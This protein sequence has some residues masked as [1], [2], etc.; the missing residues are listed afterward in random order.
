MERAFVTMQKTHVTRSGYL[1]D[2]VT[3]PLGKL[4]K[5]F[6]F[7]FITP[8]QSEKFLTLQDR[9]WYTLDYPKVFRSK[10][11][12]EGACW[13]TFSFLPFILYRPFFFKSVALKGNRQTIN[14]S[15]DWD[16][17][18]FMLW[19]FIHILSMAASCHHGRGPQLKLWS[20]GP[21]ICT[22][23]FFFLQKSLLFEVLGPHNFYITLST[24]STFLYLSLSSSSSPSSLSTTLSPPLPFFN[25]LQEGR[26]H[27]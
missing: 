21:K 15:S 13:D 14:Y 19:P 27:S 7:T 6:G 20:D 11:T 12:M 8:P 4:L 26:N 23:W 16:Y 2:G 18:L 10:F 1:Q 24:L 5:I 3:S 17:S 9:D 25:N 22:V